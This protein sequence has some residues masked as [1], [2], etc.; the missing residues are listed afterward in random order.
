MGTRSAAIPSVDPARPSAVQSSDYR[1][2]TENDLP[3]SDGVPM[4]SELHWLQIHLLVE[5]IDRRLRALGRGYAGGDMF[6]YF[7]PEQ[8]LAKDRRRHVRGP[9]VFVSLQG[10]QR[11]H[12]SWVVWNDGPL[13]IVIELLSE[14]TAKT[15]KT[16]KKRVYQ[17][18]LVVPEY[19]WF[20]P[21]EPGDF[22]GFHLKDGVYVEVAS[23]PRGA[24]GAAIVSL[25]AQLEL[26]TWVGAYRGRHSVWLRWADIDGDVLPTTAESERQRAEA[27]RQRAERLAAKLRTLGIEPDSV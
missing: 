13:D 16:E 11:L 3:Y 9:D 24:K 1:R 27:E 10:E 8:T 12:K 19:Y 21:N 22:R 23:Q 7:C 14:S 17:D 26:R 15:D 25:R 4:D 2:L 20:D 18:E 5:C 6:V